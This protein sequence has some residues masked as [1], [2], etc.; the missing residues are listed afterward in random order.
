MKKEKKHNIDKLFLE[1]LAGQQIEPSPGIWKSLTSHIPS[2]GGRGLFLFFISALLTGAFVFFMHTT[3]VKDPG[4]VA[5]A[6]TAP[7]EAVT[8][9]SAASEEQPLTEKPDNIPAE[10]IPENAGTKPAVN[11]SLGYVSDAN[12][13]LQNTGAAQKENVDKPAVPLTGN[14]LEKPSGTRDQLSMLRP[15]NGSVLA[16]YSGSLRGASARTTPE[17][18]FDLRIK[19]TYAKKADLLFGVAFSPAVNIYPDGQNRNDYSLEIVGSYERSRFLVESGIGLN[20]TSENANYRINYSSYDSVGYFI[21]VHSFS[22]DPSNPNGVIFETQI[23]SIYDSIDRYRILE[24]TNKFVY[25][26]VPLRI[27]YRIAEAR[28]FSLDLKTGILFSLRLY[29]DIP[30]VP[31]QGNDADQVEI[32]RQYPDR[33]RTTWQYTVGLSMNY[34]LTKNL[35]LGLE[36]FYRQFIRS[37]YL[38]AT[39]YPARSPHAFGLRGGIYFH[40]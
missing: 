31:Y 5:D 33:Q 2:A 32:I 30:D 14:D 6:G 40:F 35:R 25:L 12:V 13:T 26:Q 39:E 11:S 29:E 27:G 28:R 17:P 8:P 20:Y 16:S 34:H 9:E 19:D 22:I 3:L 36:P 18:V 23:T 38:P 7:P 15:L 37:V 4:A 10:T 21:G 1:A 24:N